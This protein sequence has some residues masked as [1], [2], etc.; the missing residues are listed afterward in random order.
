LQAAAAIEDL[1]IPED[2]EIDDL[3]LLLCGTIIINDML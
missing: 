2:E 3:N 1:P